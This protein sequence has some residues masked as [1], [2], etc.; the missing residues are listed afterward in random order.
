M[1][2]S[3]LTFRRPKLDRQTLRVTGRAAMALLLEVIQRHA[4]DSLLELLGLW[5]Q[6]WRCNTS[7]RFAR[8][9]PGFL[10]ATLLDLAL[11][12]L[13]TPGLSPAELHLV[14]PQLTTRMDKREACAQG[15]SPLPSLQVP[16][17]AGAAK[18]S[19][20]ASRVRQGGWLDALVVQRVRFGRNEEVDLQGSVRDGVAASDAG[21]RST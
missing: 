11:L 13:P 18:P 4:D 15:L 16:E 9:L 17:A 21:R 14:D 1:S 12:V 19:L 20:K 7:T 2:A 5:R 3:T 6:Q 8:S 10:L